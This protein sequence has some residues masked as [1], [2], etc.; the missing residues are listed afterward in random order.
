MSRRKMN[1]N[2]VEDQLVVSS[3]G[4]VFYQQV[5]LL[6]SHDKKGPRNAALIKISKYFIEGLILMGLSNQPSLC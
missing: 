2:V 4:Q 1:V 3:D 6:G 5:M